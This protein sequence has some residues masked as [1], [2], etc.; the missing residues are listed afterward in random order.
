MTKK[1]L[2]KLKK[3]LP[4]GYRDLIAEKCN[5]TTALVDMVLAGTRKNIEIVNAAVNLALSHK[6]QIEELSNKIKSI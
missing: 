2:N 6:A 4:K 3:S 1:E 5:C